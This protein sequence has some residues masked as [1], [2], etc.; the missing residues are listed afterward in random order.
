MFGHLA[1]GHGQGRAVDFKDVERGAPADHEQGRLGAPD[2]VA[3]VAVAV[4]LTGLFLEVLELRLQGNHDVVEAFQ[5]GFGAAQTQLG[6]VAAGMEAGDA[7]GLLQEGAPID[8]LGGDDGADAALAD[9]RRRA[10]PGGRIGEQEVDVAGPHLLAVDAVGGTASALDTAADLKLF[11]FVESGGRGAFRV[12]QAEQHLGDVARRTVG[13]AAKDDVV[14]FAAAHLLGRRL[15]H[16]PAQ[17]LDQVRLAA[18]V[19]ADDAGQAG[20][21]EEFRGFDEGLESGE[22]QLAELYQRLDP[23]LLF[24]LQGLF[25]DRLEVLEGKRAGDLHAVDQE[26]RRGL[27]AKPCL[28]LGGAP[29]N[30]L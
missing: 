1:L 24:V 14:H 27:D 13:G 6:L 11:E 17:T 4:R 16:N 21:N 7:G 26:G 20:L 8:G 28:G 19:G 15:A 22:P 25:D 23:S 5:V 12:V 10:R 2:V 18:T 3:E 30:A 29:L 9:Q